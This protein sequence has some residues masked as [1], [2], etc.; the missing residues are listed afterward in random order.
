MQR[1]AWEATIYIWHRNEEWRGVIDVSLLVAFTDTFPCF[2]T[3]NLKIEKNMGSHVIKLSPSVPR[4]QITELLQFL[5]LFPC[6]TPSLLHYKVK[7][8][9]ESSLEHLR[10]F[11][12]YL[13]HPLAGSKPAI[14]KLASICTVLGSGY[15]LMDRWH[16][17]ALQKGIRYEICLLVYS[18]VKD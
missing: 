4:P 8:R 1:G 5:V 11:G 9:P 18:W 6:F 15:V 14:T 13:F 17:P 3:M 16:Q 10:L 7:T 12:F 2:Q